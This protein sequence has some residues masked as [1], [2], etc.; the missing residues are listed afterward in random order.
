[1]KTLSLIIIS[2][3]TLFVNNQQSPKPE[4]L[5]SLPVRNV[6]IQKS[7]V[8]LALSEIAYK[9]SVPVGVEVSP[10]DDL[11]K[12]GNIIVQIENGTLQDILNS[13][14]SQNPLYSW[15]IEDGVVNVFP[16]G[17]REPLLKAL[18]EANIQTFSIEEGTS[19]FKFRESLTKSPELK[20]ILDKYGVTS[21]N[22]IFLSRDIA[23]LGHGFCFKVSNMT[24]KSILNQV[25]KESET[26]YWIVNKSGANKQYLLLNL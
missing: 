7:N 14:V 9:Y 10:E 17:Q 13:I 18:L 20:I 21:N 23:V 22:E 5:T 11:L 12:E 8:P 19:R 2:L 15:R 25:I 24:V 3:M 16:R 4:S 26:K 6:N 1:M